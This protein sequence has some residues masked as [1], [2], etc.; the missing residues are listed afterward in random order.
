MRV[1]QLLNLYMVHVCI[2]IWIILNNHLTFNTLHA[3]VRMSVH[4]FY[5]YNS[6]IYVEIYRNTYSFKTTLSG[7]KLLVRFNSNNKHKF[8][9]KLYSY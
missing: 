8:N 7:C 6:Y 3:Y 9:V 2:C 4:I 1:I 5:E